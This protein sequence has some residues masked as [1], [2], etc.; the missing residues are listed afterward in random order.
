MPD[1][2]S[3]NFRALAYER[4]LE[5][6]VPA[7]NEEHRIST[8][9]S[10]LADHVQQM[11][12]DAR[13]RVIDNGSADRTADVI[14]QV[15][16]THSGVDISVEGCSRQGKGRAVARGIMTSRS[17]WVGYCDADLATAPSAISEATRYLEEGW[18]VVVGSRSLPE[19][20]LV[21]E[22]PL[23]RRL[24]SA[25]FK[26]ATRA[27]V[28]DLAVADTQCGFKFFHREAAQEIFSS[29]VTHGFAFDVDVLR[30]AR[31]KGMPIKEFPVVWSDQAGSTFSAA[32]HGPEVTRELLRIRRSRRRPEL[33]SP[34]A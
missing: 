11:T 18:P 2:N 7:Y 22:Q 29:T 1:A 15:S 9:V 8:T 5:I 23:S 10:A 12:L 33:Q 14:D 17:R 25:G 26:L 21:V 24:G 20:D 32:R 27:I 19:S 30:V 4:S 34:A 31:D 16:A 6:I 28:G 3:P 13:V